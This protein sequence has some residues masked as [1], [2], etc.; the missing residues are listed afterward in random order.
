[1]YALAPFRIDVAQ[2]ALDDLRERLAR[3]RWP[4]E[5]PG[6]GWSYGVHQ[7]YLADLVEHWRTDYDWRS[8][9]ARLNSFPQFTTVIGDQR[10]HFLHV[11]SP[12]PGATPLI[13]THGWPSTVH[14]FVDVIGP[15][16]DPR[17]HG[18]DPADAFH[19]VAP[20]L[21]GFGFSGPTARTGWGV[22]RIARAWA[23]LMR[24]LGYERYGAQGGDF[25][26]LV[27]P[28]LGR[29]APENVLGVHVN[30]LADA[31]VASDPGDLALLTEEDRAKAERNRKLWYGHSGY[32]VQMST[33]PQTLAYALNDSPAGQLAWNLEWFVD[34]DPERTEQTPI[35]RDAILTNVTIFWLTGTAG[36]AARLYLESADAW[37][38]RAARTTIPT[39]VANFAGDGAVR[40]LAELSHEITRWTSYSGGGHF[41]SLQA[42]DLLVDDIRAFFRT[43][44]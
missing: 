26:S 18:G 29:I 19:V 8:H 20:S 13:I 14:D 7:E 15:L 4:G 22:H 11:R 23:E 40:G 38:R 34:W 1:M 10:V 6:V 9:E 41:A 5:L 21:P 39:G 35:D 2:E 30:A 27:S 42:P 25:G 17:A 43:L 37:G 36:S 32:A 16:T 28:E 24:R 31:A 44:R 33:R 12:E 3:T